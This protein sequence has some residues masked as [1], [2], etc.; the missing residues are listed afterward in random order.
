MQK[1]IYQN[2]DIYFGQLKDGHK[3]GIGIFIKKNVLIYIGYWK[4]SNPHGKGLLVDKELIIY[5][6]TISNVYFE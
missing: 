5:Q 3:N 1:K 2:G 6:D 4:N